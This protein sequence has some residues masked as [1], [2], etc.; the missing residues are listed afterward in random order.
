MRSHVA[1][2]FVSLLWCDL[3]QGV[4]R[5]ERT[6]GWSDIAFVAFASMLSVKWLTAGAVTTGSYCT[7]QGFL[8]QSADVS[9]AVWCVSSPGFDA[10]TH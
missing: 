8:K 1:A 4:P 7:Y 9:M 5:S 3:M 6:C 10:Y 2:Y